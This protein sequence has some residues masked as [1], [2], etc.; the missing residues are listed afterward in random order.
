MARTYRLCSPR[1]TRPTGSRA[2]T[3]DDGRHTG[4][5]RGHGLHRGALDRPDGA[6]LPAGLGDGA[7]YIGVDH[8]RRRFV[9]PVTDSYGTR[10]WWFREYEGSAARSGVPRA[11]RLRRRGAGRSNPGTTGGMAPAA[12]VPNPAIRSGSSY[13]LPE[14][15]PGRDLERLRRDRASRR[16][17]SISE[18]RVRSRRVILTRGQ[19]AALSGVYLYRMK[20]IDPASGATREELHGG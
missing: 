4:H 3:G 14:S 11:G 9:P 20:L 17:P 2:Q 15:Q 13:A 16:E 7:L 10:T 19:S 8:P 5:D 6:R 1:W 12:A 18:S